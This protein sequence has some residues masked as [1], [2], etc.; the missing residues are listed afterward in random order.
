MV[1]VDTIC[2]IGTICTIRIIYT[3][4]TIWS[5]IDSTVAVHGLDSIR[6]PCP[7]DNTIVVR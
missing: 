1:T 4:D 2:T 6:N 7:V 5:S 3:I